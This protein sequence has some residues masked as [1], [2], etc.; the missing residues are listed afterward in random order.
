MSSELATRHFQ[1]MEVRE[2]ND[3]PVHFELKYSLP[4]PQ[5]Q[6]QNIVQFYDP[7]EDQCWIYIL[8]NGKIKHEY[9]LQPEISQNL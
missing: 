8:A 9:Q 1:Q 3:I 2:L 4:N 7:K 5:V 6:G